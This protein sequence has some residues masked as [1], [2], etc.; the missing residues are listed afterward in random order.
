MKIGIIGYG[1]MGKLVEIKAKAAGH[2]VV[3]IIDINRNE[4]ITDSVDC[5]I[6]FTT[7]AALKEYVPVL[8]EKQIPLVTGTTGWYK[9]LTT[10][11]QMFRDSGNTGIWS[12]NFSVGVNL[13]WEIVKHTTQLLNRFSEEYDV[14]IHEYHH[15]NKA[16]SPSGTALSTAKI[17]LENFRKKNTIITNS[18]DRKITDNEL[19]VSSTRGGHFAGTH[20][21]IFDSLADSIEI[22]HTAHNREGFAIGAIMAAEQIK[23]LDSGLHEF[24][25]L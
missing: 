18:L 4:T 16:D 2:E 20:S 15:R 12:S 10:Y 21:L 23:N 8:C 22:K 13:F 6:D 24:T 11:K 25:I 7:A 1:R 9:D 17:V 19:H 14:M 5:Y 3:S